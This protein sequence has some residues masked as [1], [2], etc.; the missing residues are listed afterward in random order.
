MDS[1]AVAGIALFNYFFVGVSSALARL[2]ASPALL[3]H[4]D[5]VIE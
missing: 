4:T 3:A 1:V 2:D 5:E